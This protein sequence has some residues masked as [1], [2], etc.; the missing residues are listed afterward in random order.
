MA[1]AKDFEIFT[2]FSLAGFEEDP[3]EMTRRMGIE[4]T[5]SWRPGERTH[6]DKGV[7]LKENVWRLELPSKQE[8]APDLDS[9]ITA[10]LDVLEPC[11]QIIRTLPASVTRMISCAVYDETRR[12][13][14]SV[15]SETIRRM[16]FLGCSLQVDY[17]AFVPSK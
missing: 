8:G 13:T 15:A 1:I 12:V 4:P 11:S 7:V 2:W 14:L 5:K 3:G 16:A 6:G 17:Y 9:P 10:L